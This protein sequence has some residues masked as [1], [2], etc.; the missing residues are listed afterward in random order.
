MEV[1][2]LDEIAEGLKHTTSAINNALLAITSIHKEAK[3]RVEVA[4]GTDWAKN[5]QQVNACGSGDQYIKEVREKLEGDELPVIQSI[6]V[7]TST[8]DDKTKVAGYEFTCQ[9]GI[10]YGSK[11]Y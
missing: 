6:E 8:V 7:F 2:W 4:L 1:T 9:E 5:I 11:W 3:Q 10:T